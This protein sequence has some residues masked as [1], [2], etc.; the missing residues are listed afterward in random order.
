MACLLLSWHYEILYILLDD[1]YNIPEVR[2]C[3]RE[4]RRDVYDN[5]ELATTPMN[6]LDELARRFVRD[7]YLCIYADPQEIMYA[8]DDTM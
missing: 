5:M 8:D 3:T 7:A 6:K 1:M 4:L 2:E